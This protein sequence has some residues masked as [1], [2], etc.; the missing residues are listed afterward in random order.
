[1]NAKAQAASII[2]C[3]LD[4][5]DSLAMMP[6]I[7]VEHDMAM[8]TTDD[9]ILGTSSQ[10]GPVSNEGQTNSSDTARLPEQKGHGE[11]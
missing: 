10:V 9:S 7:Q 2:L 11:G 1:M 6:D 3:I 4:V 5:P 8:A